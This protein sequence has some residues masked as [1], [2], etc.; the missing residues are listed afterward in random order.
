MRDLYISIEALRNSTDL[1]HS[2]M[3]SWIVQRLD[4][5]PARGLDWVGRQR[6]LWTALGV[7]ADTVELLA[8]ELELCFEDSK[9]CVREG[10][11]VCVH[12]QIS[13]VGF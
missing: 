2:R 10:A 5:R 8:A 6:D 13:C 1:L 12:P 11:K 3:N 4:F 7:E 9:L